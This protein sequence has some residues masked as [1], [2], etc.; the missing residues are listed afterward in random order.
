MVALAFLIKEA[1]EKGGSSRKLKEGRKPKFTDSHNSLLEP[2]GSQDGGRGWRTS[3]VVVS[4]EETR[5]I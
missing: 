3:E 1:G 4:Q 5:L 2:E